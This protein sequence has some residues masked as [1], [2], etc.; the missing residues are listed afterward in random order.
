MFVNADDYLKQH[1][2]LLEEW[3]RRGKLTRDPR[4]TRIGAF[5]RRTSLDELPQMLNILRGEMSL[6]GPRAIQFKEISAY[7]QIAYIRLAVPP[8]LTGLCQISGRAD[9]PY[10]Q[11]A[12]LDYTY[13]LQRSLSVDFSILCRTLP[14]VMHGRGAY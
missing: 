6:V 13:I 7:G 5:L 4:V 9:I 3:K 10:S 2:D 14:A 11:R 12:H 8:G 1:P